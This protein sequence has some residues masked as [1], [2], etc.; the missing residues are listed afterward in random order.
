M[1]FSKMMQLP[2]H[3]RKS[4]K[5]RANFMQI[6]ET[7]YQLIAIATCILHAAADTDTRYGHGLI[8]VKIQSEENL[9]T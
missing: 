6:V 8:D 3:V 1:K 2:E 5:L 9:S 7:R 4:F